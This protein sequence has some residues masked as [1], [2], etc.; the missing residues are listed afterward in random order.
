MHTIHW[1]SRMVTKGQRVLLG[2][3]CGHGCL[4]SL[5]PRSRV[6]TGAEPERS[7]GQEQRLTHLFP[8]SPYPAQRCKERKKQRARGAVSH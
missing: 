8:V 3:Q 1:V 4:C 7:P 5:I 2:P 6:P